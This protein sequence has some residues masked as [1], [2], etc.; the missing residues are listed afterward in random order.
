MGSGWGICFPA[1]LSMKRRGLCAR[2]LGEGRGAFGSHAVKKTQIEPMN[3]KYLPVVRL[4]L[5]SFRRQLALQC[6]FGVEL[7]GGFRRRSGAVQRR[8]SGGSACSVGG[9][10]VRLQGLGI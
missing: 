5:H 7:P 3:W 9:F 4:F 2:V 8:K 10:Q 1:K 6:R